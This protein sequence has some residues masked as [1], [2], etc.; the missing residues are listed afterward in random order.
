[1]HMFTKTFLKLQLNINCLYKPFCEQGNSMTMIIF[2]YMYIILI[3]KSLVLIPFAIILTMQT[4]S[5]KFIF[6]FLLY[7]Q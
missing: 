5:T 3:I 2:K 4:M 6:I 7:M 1:M